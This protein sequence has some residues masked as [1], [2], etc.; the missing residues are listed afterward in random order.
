MVP[1]AQPR[2]PAARL[3]QVSASATLAM[4]AR[5]DELRASGKLVLDF[6]VGEADFDP[7]PGVVSDAAALL[8][9]AHGYAPVLGTA[10]LR[11]AVAEASER[12]RGY[13]PDAAQVAVTFGAKQALF[14]ALLALVDAGDEVLIPAP[15][16]VSHPAQVELVGATPKFIQ[17]RKADRWKVQPAALERAL[18]PKVKALILCSPGNPSGVTYSAEELERLAEVLRRHDCYILSAEG[19]HAFVYGPAGHASLARVAPDLLERIVIIDSVSKTYALAGWRV[20]WAIAS[21]RVI[22]ALEKVQSQSTS[23]VS[24]FA[25][26]VAT[27]ALSGPQAVVLAARERFEATRRQFAE[28]L[29]QI[30]GIACEV[31]DGGLY[32]LPDVTGL[33]GVLHQGRE[34]SS[35]RDVGL[36]LLDQAGVVGVDGDAFGAPGHLRFTL[37]T[38]PARVE[39]ALTLIRA[40][41]DAARREA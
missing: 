18:G 29:G 36:W 28:G 23:G 32:V 15:Y 40:A 6:G 37:S 34:L 35:A 30:P 14:N 11:D 27:A 2:G 9:S 13:R 1:R 38:D 39:Q 20:G 22:R 21:L 24:G 10:E 25:Q 41:V 16:W 4:N 17:A 5:V 7:P 31:P 26:G 33:Y 8:E 3:D 12:D 19:Y